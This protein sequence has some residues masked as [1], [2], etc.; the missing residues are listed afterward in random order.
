MAAT[1]TKI[2]DIESLQ[3]HPQHHRSIGETGRQ[4]LRHQHQQQPA[5]APLLLVAPRSDHATSSVA[6]SLPCSGLATKLMDNDARL[7]NSERAR[8]KE[9]LDIRNMTN[10]WKTMFDEFFTHPDNSPPISDPP[11]P[12]IPTPEITYKG[13]G[14]AVFLKP[15]QRSNKVTARGRATRRRGKRCHTSNEGPRGGA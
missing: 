10:R 1:T 11:Q 8:S 6:A 5:A 7:S 9:D 3:Q 4:V 14:A 15:Y 12:E 13:V 2:I